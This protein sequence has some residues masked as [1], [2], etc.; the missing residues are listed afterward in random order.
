[1]KR[2]RKPLIALLLVFLVLQAVPSGRT[3]PP[4]QEEIQAPAP[5]MAILRRSCYD[6]HSNLTKWSWYSY[7]APVSWMLVR[8]TN[9]ARRK[10][11]FTEWNRYD[12]EERAERI[13]EAGEQVE[14]GN[15][16]LPLYLFAHPD[17]ALSDAERQA[18]IDWAEGAEERA[19]AAEEAEQA[20]EPG[21]VCYP[22]RN[23]SLAGQASRSPS[24]DGQGRPQSGPHRPVAGQEKLVKLGFGLP[25]ETTARM[26]PYRL[27]ERE[28]SPKKPLGIMNRR[29]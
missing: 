25:P 23:R 15:M 28:R 18:L 16:P 11:N 3:N 26:A 27:P 7:V 5:V 20:E 2:F 12:A 9:R 8:D 22:F 21:L 17:K 1:M 6:C 24:E 4:V 10:M 13:E 14:E 29:N 19:E